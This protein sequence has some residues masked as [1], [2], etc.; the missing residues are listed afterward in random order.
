LTYFDRSLT[1]MGSISI[2]IGT[3]ILCCAKQIWIHWVC[4]SIKESSWIKAVSNTCQ[5]KIYKEWQIHI[6]LLIKA[7]IH[8]TGLKPLEKRY[9]VK[10]RKLNHDTNSK[11]HDWSSNSVKKLEYKQYTLPIINALPTY[12]LKFEHV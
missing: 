8:N 5:F 6:R 2:R 9:G 12:I 11:S 1:K 4:L 3:S 10:I 7:I